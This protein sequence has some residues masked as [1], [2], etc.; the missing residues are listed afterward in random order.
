M[1]CPRCQHESALTAKF[2]PECGA[3]L[4]RDCTRCGT[5]LPAGAKFC[6]EC[7]HPVAVTTLPEARFASPADYTPKHIAEK[8]LSSRSALEGE[9]KQ[10]TVLFA[11][12]KG[13]MELLADRDPEEARRLLDPVLT[14]M[15]EAVHHYEG[16]VN[17]VMGDGIMALFGAPVA[18]EDHALRACYAALAMQAMIRR[19]G[20]DIEHDRGAAVRI[21]VGLN[22]GEVVVRAIGSD[23][24]M[25]YTAVGQTTHLAARMEQLAPPGSILFTT[26][27]LRLVDGFVD[28]KRLGPTPVKGL[29]EPVEVLELV[30]AGPVRNRLQ[31]SAARG[32]SPLVGRQV[33]L[34][35][36]ETARERAAAGRGQIVGVVGEAGVGKS[37]LYWEFTHPAP[38]GWKLLSTGSVSYGKSTAWLPLLNLLRDYFGLDERESGESLREH[39]TAP[40]AALGESFRPAIPA[41]LA[42]LDVPVEDEAWRKLD[43]AQRRQATLD[44]IK[45]LLLRESQA[46]PLLL[47]IEDLHWIDSETQALLDSLV[48]SLPTSRILLLVN[49]RPEYQHAWGG[50]TYYT[51]IR[52]D[53]LVASSAEALL[54]SLLGGEAALPPLVRLLIER[55]EGN[56]FFLEET[57]RSLLETGVLAGE[58]GAHRVAKPVAGVQVPAT[59]QAVLAARIDRLPPGEKQLLQSAAVIG[60]DVPLMLLEAI[61]EDRDDELRRR[62]AHLQ[63][64]EFLYETAVFPEPEYTF[65][66]ALTLDV[67]YQS[68]LRERRQVLHERVLDALE[69]LYAGRIGEKV[70][71]LAHH[72]VRGETWIRGARYLYQA[73]AKALAQGR[74]HAAAA[75]FEATVDA[76]DRVGSGAD[77]TLKLDT[78][79][80]LWVTKIST[81]QSEGLQ[82]IG[83]KAEALARELNDGPRLARV[84]VRQAQALAFMRLFPGTLDSA[85]EQAREAY[86]RADADDLRTRGYAQFI[87]GVSCRDVGRFADAIDEFGRGVALFP[88][89]GD[90]GEEAGLVF[91]VYVSLC[92]W[93]SEAYA[94]MGE[95]DAALASAAEGLRMAGEIRHPYSLTLS[96]AFLGY[97]RVLKGDID[98]AT[99]VLERGLAI[100][101]E[102]DL[103]HGI[104]SNSLYLAYAQI[105]SGRRGPGVDALVPVF[106]L[107]NA[108]T[109]QWTRYGTVPA[110]IHMLTGRYAEAASVVDEGLGMVSERRAH[111]YLAPLLRL[112]AEVYMRREGADLAGA[113]DRLR[114]GLAL[115]TDL[116]MRHEIARCRQSLSRL[117]RRTGDSGAAAEHLAAAVALFGE[118]GA[119]FW[120]ARAEAEANELL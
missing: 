98:G 71:L 76:L 79:L 22:S 25:D 34:G 83:E 91:P 84:Q 88:A 104:L 43:P 29:A 42:L 81:N 102:H 114:Q 93:R 45:R 54:R 62:L 5:R 55:T 75:F 101:Q 77:L 63:A 59:V 7:A 48:D 87:A 97:C 33:E 37:R 99:T 107:Q 30:G 27:T 32:L 115:A 53:P 8:I 82:Q 21:R 110:A 2:C 17:Q 6:P 31:A 67:A 24:H 72:A 11:D 41:I 90:A 118:L 46:Q 112:Q 109:S 113:A 51:Q 38:D 12:L 16:T 103:P 96:N 74:P 65:K 4:V 117:F 92:G 56:P 18:H 108:F 9:R 64:A 111:G 44:A 61:A 120:A 36:L 119:P 50:R 105:L 60:K 15:M 13:S 49:Y 3:A 94:A 86:Q 85:M 47:L 52:L 73:G 58:R 10:V 57:V 68:L 26:E 106:Q 80:E 1:K 116:G 20:E 14:R 66:H 19:L 78:L 100:A 70:E 23:L 95:L 89:L 40:L 69:R 35:T 39:L 28:W